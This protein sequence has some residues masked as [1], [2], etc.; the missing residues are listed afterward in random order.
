MGAYSGVLVVEV[1]DQP[2]GAPPHGLG[3]D[4]GVLKGGLSARWHHGAQLQGREVLDVELVVLHKR[5]QVTSQSYP[6]PPPPPVGGQGSEV[7]T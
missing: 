1:D 5:K 4:E 7:S 2:K 3:R 6:P